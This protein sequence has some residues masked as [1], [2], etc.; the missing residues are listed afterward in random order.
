M[1][2]TRTKGHVHGLRICQLNDTRV[3]WKAIHRECGDGPL[4]IIDLSG[5]FGGLFHWG[6]GVCYE[7]RVLHERVSPRSLRIPGSL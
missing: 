5:A 6:R 4:R 3:S 1:Q 2:V 7:P